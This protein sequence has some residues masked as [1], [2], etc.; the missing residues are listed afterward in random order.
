MSLLVLHTTRGE[1][2]VAEDS[3][4]IIQGRAVTLR[5]GVTHTLTEVAARDNYIE[6]QLRHA[7]NERRLACR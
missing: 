6:R 2:P 1:V 4:L 5:S 7:R 3:I